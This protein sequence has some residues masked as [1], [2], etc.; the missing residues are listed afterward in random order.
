[1][2]LS[3]FIA[4]AIQAAAHRVIAERE[5]IEAAMKHHGAFTASLSRQ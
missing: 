4:E 5:L 2:P 3:D 1:L